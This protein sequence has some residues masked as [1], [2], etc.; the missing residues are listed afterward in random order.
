MFPEMIVLSMTLN[1]SF[2]IAPKNPEF[3]M[4][5]TSHY[6]RQL[7]CRLKMSGPSDMIIL[8]TNKKEVSHGK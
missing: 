6:V 2:L 7:R 3:V 8:I 5:I 1:G 4:Q